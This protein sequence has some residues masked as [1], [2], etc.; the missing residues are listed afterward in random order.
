MPEAGKE[1]R[2]LPGEP[3]FVVAADF[4]RIEYHPLRG[5]SRRYRI[6]L[7]DCDT[8]SGTLQAFLDSIGFSETK[9]MAFD[10]YYRKEPASGRR[11]ISIGSPEPK[12]VLMKTGYDLLNALEVAKL[13]EEPVVFVKLRAKKKLS[14]WKRM[15]G[16]QQ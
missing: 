16:Y 10:I 15:I 4:L 8:E 2:P 7:A 3:G 13:G 14:W 6:P 11:R 1:R 12:L 5:G 9:T